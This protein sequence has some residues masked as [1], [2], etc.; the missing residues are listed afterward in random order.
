MKAS[1]RR[2]RSFLLL[3]LLTLS[4]C[5]GGST[6]PEPPPTEEPQQALALRG[7]LSL[8]PGAG[9]SSPVRLAL[10]WYPTLLSE[11]SGPLSMPRSIA[12]QSVTYSGSFPANYT[13]ALP[14]A[15]PAEALVQLGDGRRGKGAVGILL[16]YDDRDGNAALDTIPADGTPV[17]RVLGA[18]LAWTQPPAFMVLYLDSEQT[19][20][21][22]LKR[23]FNLV[24]L[25]D[26]L[27]SDVVPLTT[28]VPMALR[29]DPMLDAFVCEAAWDDTAEQAPCGLAAEDPEG[30]LTLAGELSFNGA[31]ADVSLEVRRDGLPEAGAEVTVGGHAAAY[32]AALSRYTLHLDDA[33][34]LLDSGL[35]N[36]TARE[37][38][39]EAVRTVV[40]PGNFQVTWPTAPMSYSPG[41][42]VQAAWTQSQGASRYEVSVMAGDQVLASEATQERALKLTPPAYEGA[43][44]LRVEVV[45]E[46]S[47]GFTVR[48]TREVP[49]IF[50]A[51]DTVTVGSGLTVEGSFMQY[52]RD[53]IDWETSEVRVEVKDDGVHVTDAK[54][55]LSGWNVP[56]VREAGLFQNEIL[57]P[58]GSSLG[59]TVELRVMREDEVL[60]RTLTLP[61]DFE[62]TLE[63]PLERPTGSPLAV[64]WTRAQDAVWYELGLGETLGQPRHFAST[65]ELEYTFEQVDHV[66]NLT[67]GFAAV[68]HPAHNDTLGWMDVKLLRVG[69]AT[70]TE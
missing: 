62:L 6:Q 59:S 63:G 66:G 42:A 12:A 49:I 9:V 39:E 4:A 54:V 43:A 52:A 11:Q 37:G 30:A 40:V 36:V 20:A 31:G 33:S 19:P 56:Y 64:R 50:T 65:N 53:I 27:T 5:G 67:L 21:T 17:D 15:P 24:R 7:Q 60:C 2:S 32:D 55:T 69:S 47:D 34:A 38:D 1:P 41:E 48:R 26:N 35:V 44:A 70:F 28:P 8:S 23:G 29:D 16:A 46:E 61:G 18:S 25:T 13:F 14:D 45:A 57:G 68:T 22:G 51:C 10:A 58:P 3:G